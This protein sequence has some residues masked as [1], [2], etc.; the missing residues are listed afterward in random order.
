M[1]DMITYSKTSLKDKSSCKAFDWS[2][3]S[4]LWFYRGFKFNI[5][6]VKAEIIYYGHQS[7]P[8]FNGNSR[9]NS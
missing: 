8:T 7:Q 9:L 3:K 5:Y 1:T 4:E 2:D 6:R